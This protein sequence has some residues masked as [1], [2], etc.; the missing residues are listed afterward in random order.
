MLLQHKLLVRGIAALLFERL[1]TAHSRLQTRYQFCEPGASTDVLSAGTSAAAGEMEPAKMLLNAPR[2]AVVESVDGLLLTRP[3]LARLDGFPHVKVVRRRT[4]DPAK[5]ALVS[6]GGAGHEPLHAGFVGAG[7]LTAAVSGDVFAS[8]HV[9]AIH[10]AIA[11]CAS[12]A[13]TLCVVKNYT[14]DRLAFGLAAERARAEGRAVETV[15]VA[16]DAAVD[17]GPVTGRRG[18]A[19]TVLVHKVAGA[20]AEAGAPL[21]AVVAAARAVAAA[22]VSVTAALTVCRLPGQPVSGRLDGRAVELGLGIHG[23]PGRA[24]LPATPSADDLAVTLL[25]TLTERLAALRGS[26]SSGAPPPPLPVAVLVNN[27]GGLSQLELGVF[28]TALGRAVAAHNAKAATAGGGGGGRL[29][30][31]R[32]DVVR[33]YAGTLVTSTDMRGVSVSLLPLDGAVHDAVL[34]AGMGGGPV[35]ALDAPAPHTAWPASWGTGAVLAPGQVLPLP[36]QA[37]SAAVEATPAAAAA[38]ASAAAPVARL[39][40]CV[41]AACAALAGQTARL[42]ELDA[43][44]GDAD[45]GNTAALIAAAVADV[46]LPRVVAAA[47]SGGAGSGSFAALLAAFLAAAGDAIADAAGGSSGVLY[48]LMATA[49]GRAAGA[50]A[51][52]NAPPAA[53]LAASLGAAVDAAQAY[54]NARPGYRTMLDALAPAH[55]ALVDGAA[56]GGGGG[57]STGAQLAAAVAAAAAAGAAATAEM[58]PRAGR[59]SYVPF[60]T[61]R[62]SPDPGAVAVA[63]WMGAVAAAL[64]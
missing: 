8:P 34:A 13:G 39:A 23:E 50:A 2:D 31:P 51:V 58:V 26:A 37:A 5:V 63:T 12:A 9:R 24:T 35:A 1:V 43:V 22:V 18:I 49:G 19:G 44:S 7:C 52:A 10:A 4:V 53:V 3:D 46:A 41:T 45:A 16:D 11:S 20:L 28:T 33:L 25:G 17:G 40:G 30:L 15:Y 27:A 62:G 6:G 60:E 21:A 14:G 61:V 42:N 56:T 55:A 47:K 59:A 48:A 57:G 64:Q 54:G 29:L 36:A 38:A 32:L